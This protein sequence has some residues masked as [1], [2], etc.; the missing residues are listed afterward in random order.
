MKTKY[1]LI[2]MCLF[3]LGA[4]TAW[5]QTE[6]RLYISD[7]SGMKGSD[8]TLPVCM[9]NGV[10]VTALQFDLE[11]PEGVTLDEAS[12]ALAEARKVDHLV[13]MR[14]SQS[15][16]VYT[17]MVYS[18]SNQNLQGNSGEVITIKLHIPE[19]FQEES[20]HPLTLSNVVL[21]QVDGSNVMTGSQSGT[22]KV[23]GTPDLQVE[24][25]SANK[26]QL[27]P[28]E[29]LVVSWTVNN[30]GSMPTTAGWSERITLVSADGSYSTLLGTV[31]YD[32][33][34]SAGGV[35]SRQ[36]E[37]TLPELVGI[38]GD[39]K[40]QVEVKPY[41]DAGE[42]GNIQGNNKVLT[43]AIL[44]IDKVL[45]LEIPQVSVEENT[46]SLVRCKL[47]RSGSWQNTE[48][49][50]LTKGA[51]AR[52]DVPTTVSI[53]SGQS[54]AYFYLSMVDN[55]VL[56]NDSV[57]TLSVSGNGYDEVSGKLIIE[58]NEFPTLTV[59]AS[60]TEINEGETFQ[61][62]VTT[63]RIASVPTTIYLTCDHPKRFT[64]PAQV[65]I[66]AGEKQVTVDVVATED[67]QPDVTISA[68][69]T[70]SAAK[71]NKGE[72]LVL[73]YDNDLPEIE[74]VLTPSTISES[75]GPTA[76]MATLKRM[77]HTGNKI[78][79][80]L[81]DDSNNRLYYSTK[82]ITLEAG[83][84]EAEFTMGIVDNA[85]VDGEREF[86]VTAA[87]YISSCSCSPSGT[88][89]GVVS[90]TLTVLDDD[91]PALKLESSKS[92]L[93]EGTEEAA[94]LTITRN[95]D[96]AE[97]LTVAITSDYD[98]GLTYER[99]VTIP[100]G[101]TSVKV[102]VAVKA[103]ET[104]SDDRTVV[105][106]VVATGY[107][108]GTCWVMVT[109]QTLPDMT[110]KSV[111]IAS[112]E[113]LAGD[114]YN[115][116][117]TF[118]N[119]GVKE[120]PARST[121]TVSVNDEILTLTIAEPIPSMDEKMVSLNF[122]A[123]SV[124]GNYN[125]GIEC[126]K[127]RDF[128]E[129]L[130]F[131]N[132][133]S[134]PFIVNPAYTY[135]VETDRTN[136]QTGDVVKIS[137]KVTALK[138]G[139]SG[140]DVE[141]YVVCYGSRQAL[142]ATTDINGNFKAEYTL[143]SGMG[144]DF[145]V[146][147]CAPGEG[148]KDG[149]ATIHVYGMARTT[150]SYIKSYLTVGTPYV[151]NVPI[152][153]LSSLPLHNIKATVTDNGGHYQVTAKDITLLEGNSEAVVELTLLSEEPSTTN[154]WERVGINLS[155]EEGATMNFVLYN[156]ANI[157]QAK[158]VVDKEFI[159]TN[160]TNKKP[161]NIPV[162]LTNTGLG[163][164]GRITV[165]VPE[166]QNFFSLT[167]PTE[168]PSLSTG[169]SAVVGLCFNPEG[170]D[171]NV[172]QRGN[173]AINCENADG[174][175]VSYSLKVV[176]EE[177]GNLLVR[178]QDESTI[179]GT[180]NG[181]Y[182]YV[183]GAYVVLKDY[184]TGK[185]LYTDTTTV[186][187]A[188][189]F[190]QIPEGYYT[191]YVSASK[192]SSYM[193][194]VLVSP[195][196][197][198]EHLATISYQAI[199]IRWN[200][201]E[202]TVEDK[203]EIVSE[204]VYETQV[205]VPVVELIT[206]DTLDLYDVE[207]G[208]QLL[209][210]VT[211]V[212]RGLITANNV[213]V[214]LPVREG[215]LFTPLD[216]YAGFDL[217]PQEG[218]S[219][220]VLVTLDTQSVSVISTFAR[221]KASKG[222]CHS[223]TY[224]GWEWVCDK[225]NNAWVGKT[226]KFLLR[227]CEPDELENSPKDPTPRIE[228]PT[229][230]EYIDGPEAKEPQ[231][232]YVKHPV[233]QVDL[234]GIN[235][236]LS[237]AFCSMACFAPGLPIYKMLGLK[238]LADLA[239]MLEPLEQFM[240]II[241]EL[242]NHGNRFSKSSTLGRSQDL[243]DY[244]LD[245]LQLLVEHDSIAY[246]YYAELTEAQKMMA[247]VKTRDMLIPNLD[248]ILSGMTQM[249]NDGI[250]YSTDINSIY[251]TYIQDMPQQMPDWYDFNLRSF[252]ERQIN[253]FRIY[254]KMDVL[255]TN[256]CDTNLLEKYRSEINRYEQNIK[257]L[258][259]VDRLDMIQH[260][261]ED[262]DVIN[263]NSDNVCATVKLQFK[264]EMVFTR[265]AFRGTLVIENSTS[266]KL[267]DISPFI[268]AT[269]EDGVLA[270]GHEMQ[271]NLESI[272][273]LVETSD[274]V[275]SLDGNQTGTFTFL[276]IPT[277]FAAPNNDVTYKF[278]GSLTFNDG[279]GLK[280]HTLY[281]VAL[282]VKPTPE[283]DLT[284]F[285]QRDIFGDDPLTEIVEPMSPAEFTLLI[286][287]KGYGDATD[288]RM[289]THQPE[290]IDNEKG[291]LIDFE[292]LS[293]QLNGGEHTLA[294]DSSVVTEFGTIPAQSTAYAQWWLQSTLLGHF[295]EYDI[296]ATHVSSYGNEDLSLLD[297]V[298]IHELIR[299]LKVPGADGTT[300]AG[301][302]VNDIVDAEDMP[303]MLYLSDATMESVS[304]TTVA[305]ITMKSD[306]EY[307]LEVTPSSVG[308][309]Y[310]SIIDPTNGKQNLIGIIRQ[311]D[312]LE[313]NVRNFWQTD[314]TLRDGRDPLYENRLHFAD[315][316]G[317]ATEQYLLTFEPKPKLELAVEAFSGVPDE[318]TVLYKV[319]ET[320][321]VR[322]NKPIEAATFTTEDLTLNCQGKAMDVSNVV[323]TALNEQEFELNVSELTKNNNGYYV[324]TVQTAGIEDYE[325]FNGATGKQA[326]WI[327]FAD[328]KVTL[329]VSASP[330]DGGTVTP[331]TGLQDY[332]TTVALE[333]SPAEGFDF[334]N[335]ARGGEVLSTTPTYELRMEGDAEVVAMFTRKHYDVTL[336]YDE[337]VGTVLGG[338]TGIYDYG[339]VLTLT[340]E[341]QAGYT[342]IG[343]NVNGEMVDALRTW[344][345]TVRQAMTIEPLFAKIEKVTVDYDF[346][347]GWNW[348]SVNVAN[349]DLAMPAV[350]LEPLGNTANKL[351][352][353][354]GELTNDPVAGWIGT[355]ETIYPNQG[356][357]LQ[358]NDDV[359]F[360]IMGEPLGIDGNTITLEDGWNWI[361]YRPQTEMA[362][363][364][365]LKNLVATTHDVVKGKASFAMYD[366]ASWVGSLT[367]MSPGAGYLVQSHGVKSFN[368]PAE[369]A[370]Q[371]Y[372][373]MSLLAD[374][375]ADGMPESWQ[376]DVHQYEGNTAIVAQLYEKDAQVE[377]GTYL[378]A[379]FVNGECR[380]VSVEKNGYLFLTVHGDVENEV[381]SFMA[382]DPL[383]DAYSEIKETVLS[384]KGVVGTFETPQ[385]LSIRATQVG[386]V[387][388]NV[389]MICTDKTIRFYGDISLISQLSIAD[390]SGKVQLYLDNVPGNGVV[391][392]S[393]LAAGV[394]VVTAHTCNGLLQQKFIRR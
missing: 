303:D 328:G 179:Y 119:I 253:T 151:V 95:T 84:T 202:T 2:W 145:I 305:N 53:S 184:N 275:Y 73:L 346:Q 160:I 205:P 33:T 274:G 232:R 341:P 349:K 88:E 357:R 143:P 254:D 333:A 45:Y 286:N 3:L 228:E 320:V 107:T 293:S 37:V 72:D 191:L 76:V 10:E 206:P 343:W 190:E 207:L 342:F 306:T 81:S 118:A 271:I 54:G 161:T 156:F 220:P 369:S 239:E 172:V 233:S 100:A 337:T 28:G 112:T 208:G 176:G 267:T 197:T 165:T 314:R 247:D 134:I 281:P 99:T 276:F 270:T 12:L 359:T 300:L 287:N 250:L 64:Y 380:G 25:I 31:N 140:I 80:H 211:V 221:A 96:T 178:V 126:N 381:I 373:R 278:G 336:V 321:T 329:K 389:C 354:N 92:M 268:N 41:S 15:E 164:T 113:I 385:R 368:Y 149:S 180:A 18:P 131:N 265:Q 175:I 108:K 340:A 57:V 260:M 288:V 29:T 384:N 240:C 182:P 390:M 4:T 362:V 132:T 14:A 6:N 217:A 35:L 262:A 170:L 198:T 310:G 242:R 257:E 62:V 360:S 309:N 171:V 307:L 105:F 67:D 237:T 339:T 186:E 123:P 261:N 7:V 60:R 78:T 317:T 86:T 13:T 89:M 330:V 98:E 166:N 26:Q 135:T 111:N 103:N 124:P 121:Y 203:Y 318:S 125:I 212:N 315:K 87:V 56:D 200:V 144:G 51:D 246:L 5:G 252:I 9:D 311:S 59:E 308:W 280:Q 19:T 38:G 298:T 83:M 137:G 120:I 129:I 279:N 236:V 255:D 47:S 102:P 22:L 36:V 216:E 225:E 117:I 393:G 8:V 299:S 177:H 187:G 378:V 371:M 21:S 193:Q 75:A 379:A 277:K 109:D 91:G 142:L 189:L 194:H 153:N 23:L 263:A 127:G 392:A 174:Q 43:D 114:E 335:W 24:N 210:H 150:A 269:N 348:F 130:E 356:Y 46:S 235:E 325:G 282:L 241:G 249:H 213:C 154:T 122:I 324:L 326:T 82:S 106:S 185:T 223:E 272:E 201:E 214:E 283:L 44:T 316:M 101:A 227:T 374:V 158:L 322:F 231:L 148:L 27:A 136:Y 20:T 70:V 375:E 163:E 50:T 173:I 256:Y 358:V 353:Q 297:E 1:I 304:V 141:P 386:A 350:F 370:T 292:L 347:K 394:Y 61:L 133:F 248:A 313:I 243:R 391:D 188:V 94:V 218:R 361:S 192:H 116:D 168:I 167:T 284:Y 39:A 251:A 363:G 222:K 169:D 138:G 85:L 291:L 68:A 79:V 209:Y 238:T 289:T 387:E 345:D 234:V 159:R 331:Q 351:M 196:E 155:S 71:H 290:I 344:S 226:V 199:S 152:K 147:A 11:I 355:L 93:L 258:G 157:Q 74:L 215:F 377:N 296:E 52:V 162:V 139:N 302:L 30:I 301:F 58:D 17:F 327:Q 66:P 16:N 146:G 42:P 244:Y 40:I 312:G 110:V 382:Y 195:G 266:E 295:T 366:G 367:A 264:Q 48:Q 273:G 69:F 181:Q 128:D 219:I 224:L 90:R 34:L 230:P 229:R 319:L 204:F 323:I 388:G 32:N 352:G 364:E 183:E 104:S 365:A 376:Y 338:G 97:P 334:L 49:F 115:I 65:T 245:R 77:S 372:R 259:Y 55:D 285:M 63:E 383:T 294:L 332:G